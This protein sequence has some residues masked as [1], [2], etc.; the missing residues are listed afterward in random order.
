MKNI[1]SLFTLYKDIQMT[2]KEKKAVWDKISASTFILINEPVRKP[3]LSRLYYGGL[4]PAIRIQNINFQRR[5]Y[6]FSVFAST[7]IVSGSISAFAQGALPGDLLYPVKTNVNEKLIIVL[8]ITPED[9][10]KTE[11]I[12]ATKRLEETEKLAL[13]GKLNPTL[14]KQT[15]DAFANHVHNFEKYLTKLE[16][17]SKF[18]AIEK[19]GIFFQTRIAVHAT[20][21]KEIERNN[22]ID[23]PSNKEVLSVITPTVI[24]TKKASVKIT[25]T[26]KEKIID[27][28]NIN[29]Q[30]FV[31]LDVDTKEAE[32]YLKE[33]KANTGID[34][35]NIETIPTPLVPTAVQ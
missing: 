9:K 12:L 22:K 3:I 2:P 33:L 28:K 31:P 26:L 15:N 21:L 25:P 7:I 24:I 5:K 34:T 18:V 23:L 16:S 29:N 17:K 32:V 8:A 10:A 4:L 14:L 19:V 11:A 1:I 20:V 6:A 27:F 35:S 13:E 30:H